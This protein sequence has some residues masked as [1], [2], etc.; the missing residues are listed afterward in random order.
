MEGEQR[1][2]KSGCSG[3]TDNLM[4]DRMVTQ[5]CYRGKR[6]LSMAWVDVRKAYD[7]VDHN[8]LIEMMEVHRV[9]AWIGK[10]IKHLSASWNTK[11]VATTNQG[12]ETSTT[13]RFHKGLPQGNALCPR[14]FPLCLN[15]VAWILNATEGY[16]LSKPL[17]TRITHLLYVDDMKVFAASETKLNQVLRS[18]CTAMQDMGLHWNPKKC[19]VIHVRRG[20][21]VEDAKDVK[22][23]ETTVVKN[24]E[25]GSNYKFLG[26]KESVMQDEKQAL[27]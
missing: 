2:A 20:K 21:Q 17:S 23:N 12:S 18:T 13:I 22:L 14:L 25:S 26:I 9:P 15:P 7:S 27:T 3:T 16:R 1:G 19:T 8:W 11:I 6:N 4:I 5:D 24:L 10:V